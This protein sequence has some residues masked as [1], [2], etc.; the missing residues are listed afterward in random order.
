MVVK[1]NEFSHCRP[2]HKQAPDN[3]EVPHFCCHFDK[4]PQ[5]MLS[6]H[7]PATPGCGFVK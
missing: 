1:G 6:A 7:V 3:N 2:H 5:N 4:Q